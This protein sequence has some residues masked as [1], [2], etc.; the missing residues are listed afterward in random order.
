MKEK[1]DNFINL[2]LENE[3]IIHKVIGLYIDDLEDKKDCYQEI[4]IQSWKAYTRFEGRSSFSTWLY[5]VC[6]NTVLT[7][8]KRQP[9]VTSKLD[10]VLDLPS[11]ANLEKSELL[12]LI[13]KKLNEVD[14]MIITLHLDGYKNLEIADITGIAVNNINV[15]LYRI[16]NN[17][18]ESSKKYGHGHF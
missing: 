14:R 7:F 2:I 3:R 13:I 15:K 9:A 8:R 17:I 11:T 10:E 4:M 5:K 18:I 1:T 12:Y 16:K 6:L